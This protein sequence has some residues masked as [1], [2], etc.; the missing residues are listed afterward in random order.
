MEHI[1]TF[2]VLRR[3]GTL[4]ERLGGQSED[5]VP[6]VYLRPGDVREHE[7]PQEAAVRIAGKGEPG[8]YLGIEVT[9]AALEIDG[10]ALVTVP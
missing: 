4:W 6:F 5:H 10:P 1:F 9:E 2:I 8:W 7:S 3:V